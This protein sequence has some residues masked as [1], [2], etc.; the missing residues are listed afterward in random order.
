MLGSGAAQVESVGVF[1]TEARLNRERPPER[2]MVVVPTTLHLEG[3]VST[4][5]YAQLAVEPDYAEASRQQRWLAFWGIAKNRRRRGSRILKFSLPDLHLF[6]QGSRD[7]REALLLA[8][9]FADILAQEYPHPQ[10][11][12]VRHFKMDY[13]HLVDHLRRVE[14]AMSTT[15]PESPPKDVGPGH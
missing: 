10:A 11:E 1:W 3:E 6:W 13:D 7:D 4:I 5:V 14:D 12:L 9:Y 2:P 15:Q 8:G